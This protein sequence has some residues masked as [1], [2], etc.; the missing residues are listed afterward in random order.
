[1]ESFSAGGKQVQFWSITGKVASSSKRSDTYVSSSR[2]PSY[3]G[4][5][6]AL[7]INSSTVV[8]QEFFLLADDGKE[9]AVQLTGHDIPVRDGNNITMIGGEVS[10]KG[11]YWVR[12]INHDTGRSW[13]LANSEVYR[14]WGMVSPLKRFLVLL[15]LIILGPILFFTGFGLGGVVTNYNPYGYGATSARFDFGRGFA[16]GFLL[17]IIPWLAAAVY[18]ARSILQATRGLNRRLSAHL[19][20]Q[21]RNAAATKPLVTN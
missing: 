13:D 18:F 19:D 4:G 9:V 11:G 16:T 8:Q 10:G 20:V 3:G 14:K 15:G 12:M 7:R 21:L 17:G 5:A 6:G 2:G 1:M